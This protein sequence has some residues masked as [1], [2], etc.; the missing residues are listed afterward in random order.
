MDSFFDSSVVIHYASFAKLIKKPLTKKCY[1]YV[2]NKKYDFIL[3][4]YVEGEIK[5]RVQKRRIMYRE[6]L[7]KLVNPNHNFD[8][9]SLFNSLS[10]RDKNFLKQIYEFFKNKDLDVAKKELSEDQLIFE[11]RIENFFK[12][13][14]DDIL[15]EEGSID[16]RIL[17]IVKE[18]GYSHAD[19]LVSTSAVQAQQERDIFSFVAADKHF[20]PNGYEF[21]EKDPRLKSYKFPKLNNLYFN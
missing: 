13:L 3:C 18:N 16:K 5:R 7:N 14:V 9:S 11:M 19:C 8:K 10:D 2:K 12:F 17:S 6:V 4:H 21:L 20:S 15:V 1:D